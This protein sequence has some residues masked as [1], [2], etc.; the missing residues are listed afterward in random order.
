MKAEK[1]AR[2]GQMVQNSQP[3]SPPC[4]YYDSDTEKQSMSGFDMPLPV[5][6]HKKM[7]WNGGDHSNTFQLFIYFLF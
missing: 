3:I 2:N 6:G 5:V 7:L 4:R 1:W